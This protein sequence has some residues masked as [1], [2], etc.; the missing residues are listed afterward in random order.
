M[1]RSFTTSLNSSFGN[2][3]SK[4]FMTAAC[5]LRSADRGPCPAVPRPA[6]R[7]PRIAAR[8]PRPACRGPASCVHGPRPWPAAR[9]PS[10][11]PLQK[12]AY[13][14]SSYPRLRRQL[15]NLSP[16][17]LYGCRLN[18]HSLWTMPSQKQWPME[19]VRSVSGISHVARRLEAPLEA[20]C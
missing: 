15:P 12:S 20:G 13:T 6:S 9:G 8:G 17:R 19:G 4:S 14:L 7:G 5:C 3:S 11:P 1:F 2:F 10:A 16:S 18:S